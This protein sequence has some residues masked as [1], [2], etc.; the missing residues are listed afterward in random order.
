MPK[1]LSHMLVLPAAF[2]ELL[3]AASSPAAPA[4][5]ATLQI[6]PGLWEFDDTAKVS[7]DTVFRMRCLPAFPRHSVRSVSRNCGR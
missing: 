5:H 1:V 4:L 6:E 2:A 7:G 3:V